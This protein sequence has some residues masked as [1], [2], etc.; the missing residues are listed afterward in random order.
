M[1]YELS[2]DALI[3]PVLATRQARGFLLG[4]LGLVAGG[5]SWLATLAVLVITGFL[6]IAAVFNTLFTIFGMPAKCPEQEG[7]E[8]SQHV[9]A[10]AVSAGTSHPAL[11]QLDDFKC[12]GHD[13]GDETDDGAGEGQP[14][15]DIGCLALGFEAGRKTTCLVGPPQ[16]RAENEQAQDPAASAHSAT[17][18]TARTGIPRRIILTQPVIDRQSSRR[19]PETTVCDAAALFVRDLFRKP[20]PTFRDHAFFVCA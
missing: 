4:S 14:G 12:K 9:P 1:Y 11:L 13:A 20:V 19:S 8:R 5:I 6:F 17:L 3:E 16:Q 2:H 7:R 18:Q 15:Y 10:S